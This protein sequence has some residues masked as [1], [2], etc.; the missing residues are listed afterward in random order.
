MMKLLEVIRTVHTSD[1]VFDQ[2]SVNTDQTGRASDHFYD[3]FYDVV[4]YESF[5]N[6][7]SNLFSNVFDIL[8]SIYIYIIFYRLHDDLFH[9]FVRNL[10]IILYI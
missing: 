7:S 5:Y 10:F 3:L 1:I 4:L 6:L 9:C 8:L 2:V